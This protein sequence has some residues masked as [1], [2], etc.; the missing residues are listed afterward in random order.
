V[1]A[2]SR[3]SSF[4]LAS[5]EISGEVA[6]TLGCFFVVHRGGHGQSTLV[7]AVPNSGTP[8]APDASLH[9]GTGKGGAPFPPSQCRRT[10]RDLLKIPH[11]RHTEVSSARIFFH[12]SGR[13]CASQ[14]AFR[15]RDCFQPLR[16]PSELQPPPA[17]LRIQQLF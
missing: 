8:T 4:L 11:A 10:P 15:C 7:S 5:T 2:S 1:A 14:R 13:M 3:Q 6:D 9:R 17:V 12:R 16:I